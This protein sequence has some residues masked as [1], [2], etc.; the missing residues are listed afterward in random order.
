VDF[1]YEYYTPLSFRR[2][3]QTSTRLLS[4]S[5][6]EVASP[7]FRQRFDLHGAPQQ[8]QVTLI[9]DVQPDDV[10]HADL[11]GVPFDQLDGLPRSDL[12]LL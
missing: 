7:A 1:L 5:I 9:P 6:L 10:G 2:N 12:A 4:N 3:S 8:L 11:V